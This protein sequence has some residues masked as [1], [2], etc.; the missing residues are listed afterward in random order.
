ME[1]FNG[2]YKGEWK[3]GSREGFG[4]FNYK[5]GDKYLGY[6][7][8]NLKEGNGRYIYANGDIFDGNFKAG[9]KEGR[10]MM[11]YNNN[12]YNKFFGEWKNDKKKVLE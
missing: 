1:Y 12:E 11:I 7:K 5:S 9:K 8:N 4:I 10:G 6:W 3:N 2:I